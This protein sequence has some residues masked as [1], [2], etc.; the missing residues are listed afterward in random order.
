MGGGV[1]AGRW[2]TLGELEAGPGHHDVEAVALVVRCDCELPFRTRG[3]GVLC[4]HQTAGVAVANGYLGV[5][6][7]KVTVSMSSIGPWE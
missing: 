3:L 1:R 4:T 7:W 6:D 5:V 2:R